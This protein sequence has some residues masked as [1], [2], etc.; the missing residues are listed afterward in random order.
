[1]GLCGSSRIT[2]QVSA[3]VEEGSSGIVAAQE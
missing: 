2:E 1:V 3:S